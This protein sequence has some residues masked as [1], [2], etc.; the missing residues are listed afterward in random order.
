LTIEEKIVSD[1][2]NIPVSKVAG[3]FLD[4]YLL[5]LRDAF[6]YNYSQTTDGK[7]Y[8]ENAWRLTNTEYNRKRLREVFWKGGRQNVTKSD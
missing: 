5:L 3:L 4:D 8:L 6:I 7:K 1:Y 2:A